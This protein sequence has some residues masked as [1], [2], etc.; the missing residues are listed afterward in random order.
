MDYLAGRL[1]IMDY[2]GL[3]CKDFLDS[4]SSGWLVVLSFHC[5]DHHT[6]QVMWNVLL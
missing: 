1:V 4:L 5:L 6:V 2:V 3:S